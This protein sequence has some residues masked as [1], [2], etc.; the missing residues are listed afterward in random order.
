MQ[1]TGCV[2]VLLALVCFVASAGNEDAR[3]LASKTI[4]NNFLVEGKD[5]TVEYNL[6]NVGGRLVTFL[7]TI[8]FLIENNLTSFT[9]GK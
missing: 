7:Q 3:L 4:L 8:L 6:Y 1:T 2:A 5:L 9:S